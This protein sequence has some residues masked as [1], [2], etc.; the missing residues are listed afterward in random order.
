MTKYDER[1]TLFGRVA[2]EKDS[3]EYKEYYKKHPKTRHADD[4]VRGLSFR[5]KIRK[6]QAFKDLFLPL[7]DHNKELISSIFHTAKNVKVNPNRQDIPRN[8][9]KN[10]KE[11][12]KYYGA[13]DVGIAK[14]DETNYYSHQAGLSSA[15]GIDNLNKKVVPRYKTAIV[16]TVKMDLDFM[17]RA[18]H[19]EELL[20]T[21][22][23]YLKV[24]LVGARLEMYLKELGY[25]AESQNGEY[26]LAPLVPLA[27]DAGL[28][29]IG[30][31][32]HIVTKEHGN[33]VRLGAVLTTLELDYDK[34]IDFGL[35]DFCKK[36]ALCLMNCPSKS[37]THKQRVVN[38]RIF[39]KFNDNTCYEQ[40]TKMGT[41]C[42]TCIQACPL[43][44]GVDLSKLNRMKE[45]PSLM[46]DIMQEHFDK[47]GRRVYTKDDLPIVTLEE[48]E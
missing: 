25:K 34:P 45:E 35:H 20:T 30:M 7:T 19:F 21:E 14:L 3:K 47:H 13:S 24:A 40:W 17:N 42:G 16:F 27:H 2:L 33:N 4:A 12:T 11:I 37:I 5:E 26:Y 29:Q 18:P 46:D 28:G 43:T 23:A 44:Q 22:D 36:C 15:L 38:G 31:A 8:F 32:N 1:N 48:D 10:I 39:Y 6:P 41:D 9:T